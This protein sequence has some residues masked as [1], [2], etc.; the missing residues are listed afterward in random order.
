MPLIMPF[1]NHVG[2]KATTSTE[3]SPLDKHQSSEEASPASKSYTDPN[4]SCLHIGCASG[5]AQLVDSTG[6][7]IHDIQVSSLWK[8]WVRRR[9]TTGEGRRREFRSS[10]GRRLAHV[11]DIQQYAL[12]GNLRVST[13]LYW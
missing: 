11:T 5:P 13:C 8:S 9:M 4:T 3:R 12:I 10:E 6:E 1:S 2:E 7:K